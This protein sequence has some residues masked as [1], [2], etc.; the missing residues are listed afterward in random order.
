MLPL[1]VFLAFNAKLG[2]LDNV[3]DLFCKPSL[4]TSVA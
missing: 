1:F 2:W 3:G 4:I